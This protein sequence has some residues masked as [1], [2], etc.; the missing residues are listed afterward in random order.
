MKGGVP[1]LRVLRQFLFVPSVLNSSAMTEREKLNKITEAI[2][3][4]AIRVHRALGPGLL[5]SATASGGSSMGP[6]E[7]VNSGCLPS[8]RRRVA[9][10]SQAAF[11]PSGRKFMNNSR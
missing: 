8:A 7:G 3:G 2:I 10:A 5:E 4:A 1:S 9:P 11:L 6:S